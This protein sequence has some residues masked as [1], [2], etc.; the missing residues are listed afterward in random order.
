MQKN[1]YIVYTKPK[2]EKKV[3]S[4]FTKRKIEHFLPVNCRQLNSVRKRKIV[5]EPLF[6]S[7]IFAFFSE[8]DI[9]KIK[10]IEGV[11]NLVYWKGR[12]ATVRKNEIEAIREFTSD[13]H[14]IRLE[15]TQI[16]FT[17]FARVIDGPEYLMERNILTIK[18]KMA[19]VNLPSLGFTMIAEISSGN[20][21]NDKV[22]FGNKEFL[23]QS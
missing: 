15:K 1:W 11:L 19:K 4:T 5:Y 17:G 10:K 18:N 2:C 8:E 23:F 22:S 7:Y 20:L 13:H 14:D 16:D 3:A 12:P 6:D 9:S 21:F